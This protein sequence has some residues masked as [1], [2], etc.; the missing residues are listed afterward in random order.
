M[1]FK[2]KDEP[3][4]WR[5]SALLALLGLALLCSVMAWRRDLSKDSWLSALAVLAAAALAAAWRPRWFRGYHL[6]TMRLGFAFSQFLGRALLVLFFLFVL[7]PV[8]WA[9]RLL[10]KDPLQIKC[11][12][13]AQTYWH[14]AKEPGP[15]DRLF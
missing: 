12:E 3:R 1:K 8:G 14:E 15:L 7:T 11:P 6:L 4:E 9:L 5:K 2:L 13:G 10:G